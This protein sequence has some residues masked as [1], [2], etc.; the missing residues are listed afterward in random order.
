MTKVK[1]KKVKFASRD[2]LKLHGTLTT[3]AGDA[4]GLMLMVHGITSDRSEWG[5]FDMLAEEVAK[6]GLASLRFDFRGHGNSSLDEQLITLA[7]IMSDITAAWQELERAAGAPNARRYIVGSSFGGGLA[8]AM[9]SCDGR[10]DRA[11]LVAPV[12]DYLADIDHCAP[13]WRSDLKRKDHFK[14]N[15]LTLGR[16]LANEALY[17][18]PLAGPAV[19]TTIFHGTKDTDVAIDLS[20][21][22]AARHPGIELVEMK[23]AGHVMNVPEDY[24]LE[25]EKSWDYVRSMVGDI[26]KAVRA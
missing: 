22:V 8:Y 12:F 3:P 25:D 4:E 7:G 26:R 19:S 16:A 21:A 1:S 13:Q 20:R 11:F 23:G 15:H 2:S 24:D 9:A 6:E 14:Y 18:E 5:I 10:F 17:L